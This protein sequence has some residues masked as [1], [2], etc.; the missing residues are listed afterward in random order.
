[1]GALIS[2][3]RRKLNTRIDGVSIS[4]PFISFRVR[5]NDL[6]QRVAREIVIRMAD[7][8]VLNASECCDNCIDQALE[9]LQQI[10]EFLVSKQVELSH[11]LDSPL[12]LLIEFQLEAIRQFLT[13]EQRLNASSP[14]QGPLVHVPNDFRRPR[15]QREQYF[16]ALENAAGS[17]APLPS[18]DLKDWQYPDTEDRQTNAV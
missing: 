7:K 1:M 16:G 12:Y 3:A 14:T 13:F 6:E 18:T 4:L 10:R 9:S 8:R 17:L 2:S 11:A 15:D 5:P